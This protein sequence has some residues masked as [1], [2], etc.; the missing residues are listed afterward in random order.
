MVGVVLSTGEELKR[1]AMALLER[2]N[3]GQIPLTPNL[4]SAPHIGYLLGLFH[5]L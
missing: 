4:S 1:W 2:E 3:Q 5:P